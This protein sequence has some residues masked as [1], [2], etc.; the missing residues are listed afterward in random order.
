VNQRDRMAGLLHLL[1]GETVGNAMSKRVARLMEHYRQKLPPPQFV[2]LSEKDVFLITY[3]DQVREPGRAP[4]ATL[5]DF[6]SLHVSGVVNGIHILPFYPSSSDDGFSVIDYRAVDPALGTWKETDYI[7]EQF[8]L[9][10]DGVFNHV[11]KESAWFKAFL[12]DDH[13]YRNFF[14]VVHGHPEVTKVVRPRALPLLTEFHTAAGDKAVWTTFSA[15]QIDLDYSNP[16]V[17]IA[18][19]NI[20]LFYVAHGV[21]WI[22]LDA[23]AYLWKEP[24]TP[25][26][27]LPQTH[28]V[29]QL[30]RAVLDEVAPQVKL[31]TETNVAHAE[32]ISYFGD[33][34]NE[35][36]LVY[37]FALPP[38]VLHSLCSGNAQKLSEWAAALAFPSDRATFFNFLASHDGIGLN[39]V[40]GLLSE[41]DINALVAQTL[42]CGGLVSYA[43]SADGG[44]VAYELNVNYFDALAVARLGVGEGSDAQIDRFM[45]AQSIMLSLVGVP[46]IYFHSLFG[47]QGWRQGALLTGLNRAINRQRFARTELES[48]LADPASVRH[49]VFDRYKQLLRARSASPAFHPNGTQQVLDL[50]AAIFALLRTSPDGSE[51]VLC[52]HNVT[53]GRQPLRLPAGLAS[54]LDL[55]SGEQMLPELAEI[56]PFR[57]LWLKC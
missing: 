34:C 1:Y 43:Q 52:L 49:R 39:P 23:I 56:E 33:G 50:G 38:L 51:R 46:G 13:F 41:Q 7:G 18:I 54:G 20:L 4:L 29:I 53:A 3:P 17:L 15:D 16:E 37:N 44:Q 24:G 47:S 30:F 8:Q 14:I 22:R 11:S 10:F 5:H 12:D 35:A 36:Q 28:A 26:I 27:H 45:T 21:S 55:L 48:E 32:N 25:C 2:D 42:R 31:V 40:R 6:C 9:M 19:L 57:T